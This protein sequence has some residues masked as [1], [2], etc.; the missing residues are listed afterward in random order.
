MRIPFSFSDDSLTLFMNGGVHTIPNTDTAF[1]QVK[2]H[3]KGSDHDVDF[4]TDLMDKPAFITKTTSGRV[5]VKGNN[6]FFEGEVVHNAMTNK[7]LSMLSEGFDVAPWISFMENLMDN[8]S[9]NSRTCLYNFLEH[10]KTPVTEDGC[11]IAFK[12]V[13]G[14]YRDVHTG[15]MDNSP[16]KVVSM[17]RSQVDD[18]PNNTCSSGLHAC[19]DEYLK[20]FATGSTYRTVAVK[21]NPRDVVAVPADYSFS[22][23]RVCEYTVLGD[24]SDAQVDKIRESDYVDFD[25]YGWDQYVDD[26]GDVWYTE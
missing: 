26:Q 17:P 20:G 5:E 24:V 16:G 11:F 10:F 19:A 22:K 6:V 13:R 9:Y 23:M 15:T 7:L 21:I 8:P 25:E 3:L 14:N 12:R 4:L 18:N 1:E 2:E